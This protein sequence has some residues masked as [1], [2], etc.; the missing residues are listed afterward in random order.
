[1]AQ[2]GESWCRG[3]ATVGSEHLAT[4]IVV[5]QLDQL[6]STQPR[7][8]HHS[9]HRILVACV[10]GEEHFVGARMM[11]DLCSAKGWSVDFLG[12]NLP[13]RDLLDMIK[14]RRPSL[15]ALSATMEQ[16]ISHVHRLLEEL[17][18]LS[19]IP[20]VLLG[21]QAFTNTR[22][23]VVPNAS[24]RIATDILRGIDLAKTLLQQ[25]RPKAVLREYLLAL[26]RRVREL[27]NQKAWT[28]EQ[29]AD[30][31]RVARACI[32]AVEGG[33]Q[34]VSMDIVVRIAN[35]LEIPPERLLTSEDKILPVQRRRT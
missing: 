19:E 16:G 24:Y 27:R 10:E 18:G 31:S 32:V 9:A 29:L 17:A 14:D 33:R 3:E 7:E 34:N 12:P 22:S 15:L 21:G 23:L 13:T 28:Q 8:N 6:R 30:A 5:K 26:G 2:I 25:D 20:K 1:M 35:A 11:A 4:Q